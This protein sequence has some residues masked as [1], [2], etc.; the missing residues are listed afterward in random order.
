MRDR[1]FA[2]TS[3]WQHITLTRDRHPYPRR[4]SNTAIPASEGQQTVTICRAATGITYHLFCRQYRQPQMR[5]ESQNIIILISGN[6][7]E[8]SVRL[9][10]LYHSM[11]FGSCSH[12]EGENEVRN[13]FG[14]TASV[15]YES[16]GLSCI[17]RMQINL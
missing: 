12:R 14:A 9:Q 13:C 17:G 2:E 5:T 10:S 8:Y 7:K 16:E 15:S 6:L 11:S 1:S 3:S 4:D